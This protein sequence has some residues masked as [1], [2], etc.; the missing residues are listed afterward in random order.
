MQSELAR[1]RAIADG[2]R[3]YIAYPPWKYKLASERSRRLVLKFALSKRVAYEFGQYRNE[4]GLEL[5]AE[6]YL[7]LAENKIRELTE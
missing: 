3:V 5:S 4:N 2:G 6:E 1:W 7:A